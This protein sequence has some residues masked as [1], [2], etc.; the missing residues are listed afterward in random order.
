MSAL[1]TA[2]SE[3]A[4][5]SAGRAIAIE[6]AR[7]VVAEHP[8]TTTPRR[9]FMEACFDAGLAWIQFPKGLGGLGLE[10]GLQADVDRILQGAGGPVP[11]ALN[12]MG[13]GMAGPTVEAHGSEDLK[14]QLLRPLYICDEIWCQ[15]FSEPG[16]GSDLA[17]LA[18][19]AVQADGEWVING[20]KVW[21]SAAHKA[22]RALLLARTDPGAPK[23]RGLTYFVLDM[24]DP[25]VE[26]RPLRQMTG[27][28]EFNEVYIRDAHIPDA[29]R[30]GDVGEGWRVA[31]TTLMNERN[32]IGGGSS[33]RGSGSIGSALRLWK[34]RPDLRTPAL[35]ERLLSLFA[36]ADSSRLTGQRHRAERGDAAAG[37]RGSIGKLVGAELNQDVYEFC[38]DMLGIEGTIYSGY[39][40]RPDGTPEP[41]DGEDFAR[42]F[43]RSRAN[44]IEGGTSE[45]LRNVIGERLLG[46]SGDIRV[47]IG[48]AWRDIPRG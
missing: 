12:P 17:G 40:P 34:D 25:G 39:Q 43:L 19:S 24:H 4:Q 37:P 1:T 18:T 31:M 35:R 45:V 13:Y 26:V 47:D 42:K 8:P 14:R 46:L 2:D 16:A 23:H 20:Q 7:R 48:K 11:F 6:T 5:Q 22:R 27:E 38:M 33:L 36:R 10:P 29:H 3:P 41:T 32:A 28:A 30:L 15:L 9:E 44:T 21:T